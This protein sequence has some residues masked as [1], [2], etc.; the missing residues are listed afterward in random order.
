MDYDKFV[1]W[2]S[3]PLVWGALA[4]CL[5]ILGW[6]AKKTKTKVDDKIVGFIKGALGAMRGKKASKK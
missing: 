4:A 5:G 1:S 6:V 2:I 3:N